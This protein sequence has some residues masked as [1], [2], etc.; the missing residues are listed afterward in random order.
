M[1]RPKVDPLKMK[2][3]PLVSAVHSLFSQP[4]VNRIF[5]ISGLDYLHNGCKP[6]IVHRDVKTSNILLM[7]NFE[8]KFA[9]F[10]LSRAFD[11][12]ANTYAFT[13]IA[14]TPGYL[15]PEYGLLYHIR[16]W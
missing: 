12:E 6:P 5:V 15:D 11:D 2:H 7:E 14:G 9:D 10:G 8:V 3:V 13:A 4:Y 1:K 16:A